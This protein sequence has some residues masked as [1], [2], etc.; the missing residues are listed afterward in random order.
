MGRPPATSSTRSP[1]ESA[2]GDRESVTCIASS[3]VG[4]STRPRGRRGVRWPPSRRASIGRPKARVLPAPVAAR[5][6]T[7]RP[8]MAAGIVAA[9][10]GNGVAMPS[11]CMAALT[12]GRQTELG[13]GRQVVG[14]DRGD[15]EVVE[16]GPLGR[17]RCWGCEPPPL[18]PRPRPRE[19]PGC[20]PWFW[21]RAGRGARVGV[22]IR[23]ISSRMWHT[24]PEGRQGIRRENSQVHARREQYTSAPQVLLVPTVREGLSVP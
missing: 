13:E 12:G 7:S 10:T 19:R 5:P 14:R 24:I 3:R 15:L 6:I 21:L 18:P 16:G 1:S 4:T 9:W 20:W 8:A 23:V 17:A 2:S 22:D 11:R